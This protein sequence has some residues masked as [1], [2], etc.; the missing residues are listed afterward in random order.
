M[1]N[2]ARHELCFRFNVITRLWELKSESRT[3]VNQYWLDDIMVYYNNGFNR[4]LV[5]GY[6]NMTY[7]DRRVIGCG[8]FLGSIAQTI[9]LYTEKI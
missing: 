9:V 8:L 5:K 7:E 3:F 4:P 2:I 1:R 6:D